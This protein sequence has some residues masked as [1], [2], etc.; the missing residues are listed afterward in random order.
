MDKSMYKRSNLVRYRILSIDRDTNP[1]KIDKGI[2]IVI[3]D[4]KNN[5]IQTLN[6]KSTPNGVYTGSMQL[7]D[8]PILG[9]WTIAVEHSN[10]V[11]K[12][13]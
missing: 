9:D 7:S 12:L 13:N 10:E 6:Q 5:E 8:D 2:S 1:F 4:P 11:Y 3:R